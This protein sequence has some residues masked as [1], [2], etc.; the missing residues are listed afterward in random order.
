[1]LGVW[2]EE[3]WRGNLASHQGLWRTMGLLIANSCLAWAVLSIPHNKLLPESQKGWSS[4]VFNAA[5]NLRLICAS[6]NL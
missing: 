5:F 2:E 6:F 3:L 1:M 4:D